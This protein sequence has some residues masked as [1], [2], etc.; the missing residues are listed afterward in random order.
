MTE[1]QLEFLSLIEGCK[2]SSESTLVKMPYCWKSHVAAQL[3]SWQQVLFF[4]IPF[5]G[6]CYKLWTRSQ[7]AKV[8]V[9]ILNE[10]KYGPCRKKTSFRGLCPGKTY[11][12]LLSYK[13]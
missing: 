9:P 10:I 7:S 8:H 12:C 11:I 3:F 5:H 1:H 2:G 6:W 4:T 13:E